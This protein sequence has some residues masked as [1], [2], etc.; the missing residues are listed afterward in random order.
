[1]VLAVSISMGRLPLQPVPPFVTRAGDL[2][3]FIRDGHMSL[4]L[5]TPQHQASQTLPVPVGGSHSV[6]RLF[7]LATSTNLA[8]IP[9]SNLAYP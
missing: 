9:I 2:G 7:E 5:M 3:C 1:M 8:W 6:F 4:P